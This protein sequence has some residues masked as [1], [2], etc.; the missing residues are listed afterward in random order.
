MACDRDGLL[1]CACSGSSFLSF[2]RA[3]LRPA[4]SRLPLLSLQ[5]VAFPKYSR[6]AREKVRKVG[7]ERRI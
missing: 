4:R 1:P 6:R 5:T 3:T 2:K 7:K